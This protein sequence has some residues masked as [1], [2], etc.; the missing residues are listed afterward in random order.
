[1]RQVPAKFQPLVIGSGRLAH[2]LQFFYQCYG[3][4][5][6][7]WSRQ[8]YGDLTTE[9]G[10]SQ[11]THLVEESSCALIAISDAQLAAFIQSASF[12]L[13][14]PF[15][16]CSGALHLEGVQGFH[17]LMTFSWD[18][19]ASEIYKKIPW[20]CA[21]E[22]SYKNRSLFFSDI[23]MSLHKIY[24][25]QKL[26]YHSLCSLLVATINLP[27]TES[28]KIFE[29]EL[30]LP[31]EVLFPIFDRIVQNVK[32]VGRDGLTG[33][34]ARNDTHLLAKQLKAL[35]TVHLDGI[36]SEL[37]AQHQDQKN[38]SFFKQIEVEQ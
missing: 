15:A 1:M 38:Q 21:D 4:E 25:A 5:S 11:L 31:K 16:H 17:P 14:Y 35:E 13:N 2:H 22:E 33:P 8:Q 3:I 12:P 20:I 23:P 24:P 7:S 9:Q 36:Y 10:R 34:I 18:L 28:F 29:Q 37:I 27:W 30:S 26:L 32:E 6:L 19:Y